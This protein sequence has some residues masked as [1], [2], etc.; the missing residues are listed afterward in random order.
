MGKRRIRNL[1]A[2]NIKDIHGLDFRE[3][4]RKEAASS[5]SIIT[6]SEFDSAIKDKFDAFI[7]SVPPDKHDIY[8]QKA[9]NLHVPAFIEASVLDTGFDQ[10][11]VKARRE[12]VL[13][14]PSCTLYYHPAIKK[15]FEVVRSKQLGTISNIIYHSG[16]YLPDWHTYE[17]V[18]DYYVSNKSTGGA[19]EIVP[20]ELTWL[21]KLLGFPK[22]V[23]GFYKK[24][25]HISGAEK[26]DDTY[27]ALMEYDGLILNLTI[28]VVSRY[29]TR[30]LVM[31]GDKKQLVWSWDENDIKVYDPEKEIWE[32]IPYKV[33]SS[34]SGYNKNITEQMYIEEIKSFL[35]AV[36][37]EEEFPNTMEDD[38]KVLKL[39]YSIEKSDDSNQIQGVV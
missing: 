32:T 17:A 7:I 34:Q 35:A 1:Q 4:R 18:S 3:D 2:N 19:R 20:F 11:I 10:L 27:N 12:K 28:D 15:I 13:L 31:N 6:H 38:H 29:A 16:Q 26:I 25:I 22:R 14:C 24:T 8:I 5:Y 37:N 21:T 30:R 36:N 33:L 9:I 23:T 39:L